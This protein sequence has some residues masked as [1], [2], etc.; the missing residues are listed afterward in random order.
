MV[1]SPSKMGPAL[2]AMSPNRQARYEKMFSRIPVPEKNVLGWYKEN[3]MA[4]FV[5]E[6][7]HDQQML[8][9]RV[10][11]S[12][13]W[14]AF[15]KTAD[16]I[17][18]CAMAHGIEGGE[19]LLQGVAELFCEKDTNPQ[20]L[21]EVEAHSISTKESEIKASEKP[22]SNGRSGRQTTQSSQKRSSSSP[23]PETATVKAKGSNV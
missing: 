1:Q 12:L 8:L 21:S 5:E 22:L 9:S 17:L 23:N 7:S 3:G 15:S 20:K 19:K 2:S 14:P 18:V 13:D 16:G 4:G 11:S 6:L 10:P